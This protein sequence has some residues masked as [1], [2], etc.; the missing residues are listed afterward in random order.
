[1]NNEILKKLVAKLV[2]MNQNRIDEDILNEYD[3]L[4]QNDVHTH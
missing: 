4:K 1:M 2:Q 3:R